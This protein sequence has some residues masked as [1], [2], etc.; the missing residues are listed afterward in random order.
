[1]ARAKRAIS[2]YRRI[3]EALQRRAAS[4]E[5]PLVS[6]TAL[7]DE[8]SVS[9]D[10]ARKALN[11]LTRDGF[12]RRIQG[13][14][15]VLTAPEEKPRHEI[16]VPVN[17]LFFRG[18]QREPLRQKF[19]ELMDGVLGGVDSEACRVHI[20]LLRPSLPVEKQFDDLTRGGAG[21]LFF[22]HSGSEDLIAHLRRE[23]Y[24]HVVH[25][26]LGYP[27]NCVASDA[28]AGSLRALETLI[29][30][31]RRRILFVSPDRKSDWHAPMFR[32]WERA[33]EH[34][35]LDRGEGL[36]LDVD[37]HL[38]PDRPALIAAL[39]ARD[40]DGV[41][42]T[43]A[44]LSLHVLGALEGFG[45]VPGGGRGFISY[46]DL[47]EFE[48]RKP[49]ISAVRVPLSRM[50]ERMRAELLAMLRF[51]YRDEVRVAMDEEL[52]LRGSE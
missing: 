10:T 11:L 25:G 7:M 29:A 43:Q 30:R 32:S 21:V 1:M 49:A 24:P 47:P 12:A 18:A 2:A 4:G 37:S 5:A 28:Q 22:S 3:Y 48:E 26:P 51:G 23:R 19:F 45:W 39:R 35:G 50:G 31:G 27:G 6:E 20:P 36:V 16:Q 14:G 13:R 40:F 17:E 38:R 52:V 46:E 34:H 15:T 44:E 41:F 42:S 9:R 33:L 8:F